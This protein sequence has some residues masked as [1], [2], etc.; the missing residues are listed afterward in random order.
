MNAT[1]PTG[2]YFGRF[3]DGRSAAARDA[4][5][6]LDLSGLEIAAGTERLRWPYETLT[7]SEPIRPHAV[8]VV[9]S[10]KTARSATLFVPDAKFAR[11][12]ARRAPHL[13]HGQQ[14]WRHMRPWLI[15]AAIAG[16]L[17]LLL[18]LSGWS[19]SQSIAKMLPMSW[20]DRLGDAAISSMAEDRRR[21]TNSVGVAALAR[22]ADRLSN[23]AGGANQFRIVVVD[24]DMLNAF[25][26][27]GDKIIMTRE[28][29]EKAAGPDEVAGVLAHEMGH[30]IEL[31]PETG[32]IR[33]IGMSAAVE[34]M[35]GGSSGTLANLGLVLAQL[36]YTRAA[37]READLHAVDLLR[38]A[39][40][41]TQGLQDFFK[42]VSVEEGA[43]DEAQQQPESA[44]KDSSASKPSDAPQAP[45]RRTAK[46][47]PIDLFRTHPPSEERAELLRR[48]PPY[49]ATPALDASEW[50]DLKAICSATSAAGE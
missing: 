22:M 34:L 8:D 35:M 31:H 41:S 38:K 7:S 37:E 12:I 29:I 5:V 46:S 40:I 32:I 14:R 18:T 47:N 43:D 20:R 27:P 26:V 48:Q 42:R 21:C 50:R 23:A 33:A 15:T 16:G 45:K 24:W 1:S 28:L 13:S 25:A 3:S 17:A 19:P 11:E 10:S 39:S 44:D 6:R 30:G 4:S 9:L 2:E 36:G 49:P